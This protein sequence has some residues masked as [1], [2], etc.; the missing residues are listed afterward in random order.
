MTPLR[1]LTTAAATVCVLAIAVPPGA[2]IPG[3]PPAGVT[4]GRSL[5]PAAPAREMGRQLQPTEPLPTLPPTEPFP[6]LPSDVPSPSIY[7]P[8]PTFTPSPTETRQA[9]ATV[10]ATSSTTPT[11]TPTAT[12]TSDVLPHRVYVP[13]CSQFYD[14]DPQPSLRYR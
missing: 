12:S 2:N 5:E 9:T 8:T 7:T 13:N 11:A 6:T 3:T 4:G 1:S 10:S 14:L